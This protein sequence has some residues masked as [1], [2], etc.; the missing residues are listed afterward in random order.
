[1][2]LQADS[3]RRLQEERDVFIR[4]LLICFIFL[5]LMIW[6]L[7]VFELDVRLMAP[8]RVAAIKPWNFKWYRSRAAHRYPGSQCHLWCLHDQRGQTDR[9]GLRGRRP[10]RTLSS[11]F[12]FFCAIKETAE[13]QRKAPV[14]QINQCIL[15]WTIW[16]HAPTTGLMLR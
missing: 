13:S 15:P 14:K 7:C 6:S 2:L 9:G 16:A 4:F 11:F 10:E 1:M 8:S 12:F 5:S 3:R